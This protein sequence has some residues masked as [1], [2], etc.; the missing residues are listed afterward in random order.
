VGRIHAGRGRIED[1]LDIPP[2][3]GIQHVQVDRRGIV[4]DVRVVFTGK[5][6]AGPAHI[7]RKLI[8]LVKPAI[9]SRSTIV[10]IAQIRNHE[11]VGRGFAEGRQ[12]QIDAPH[13]EALT[14]Q[15]FH[16][17]GSDK[18]TCPTNQSRFH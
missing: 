14:L 4:H 5:D 8:H 12:L 7:G 15:L 17:M 6:V 10:R 16:K 13:P 18:T 1:S 2:D 3:T 9:H 11:I